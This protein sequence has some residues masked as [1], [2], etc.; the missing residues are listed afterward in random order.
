[1]ECEWDEGKAD[2]N[3]HKHGVAFSEAASAFLDP[4]AAIF[5]DPDHS[6]EEV[7]EILVGNSER[8]RLLVVSFTER[9]TTIRIISARVASSGEWLIRKQKN[10]L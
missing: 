10:L 5:S 2:A 7:R 6:D 3:D 9:A 4:L 8:N 1:M